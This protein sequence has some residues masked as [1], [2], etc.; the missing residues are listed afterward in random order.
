MTERD[1]PPFT[2][3]MSMLRPNCGLT[4]IACARSSLLPEIH[5]LTSSPAIFSADA[6]SGH[7]ADAQIFGIDAALA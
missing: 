5:V 1:A 6:G 7:G 4:A 2:L 3:V